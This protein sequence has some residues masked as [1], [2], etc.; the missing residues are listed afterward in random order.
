[1]DKL[2]VLFLCEHNSARS[3]MAE[4]LLKHL[5]GEKYEVFSTGAT[6]TQVNS[7]AVE[8]MAEIGIDI[9]QHVSKSIEE[10]RDKEVDLAVSVCQ[11]SAKLLCS[12]CASP[13]V[14]GRLEMVSESLHKAK[15]YLHHGFAD[16]SEVEGSDEEKTTAFR[17]ARDEIKK[18]IVDQ[19]ADP[20]RVLPD[21][22]ESP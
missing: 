21:V 8:V 9:S 11:S 6:P 18:W 1:M 15:H 17:R 2:S 12:L 13:I 4:G 22:D 16:P 19:F 10:F 7:L 5:Y 3:Q 14:D 20:T